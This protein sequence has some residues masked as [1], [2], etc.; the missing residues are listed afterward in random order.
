MLFRSL[1]LGSVNGAFNLDV[2][3]TA[4]ESSG[5][6]R[7]LSSPRGT[8]Q[9]NVEAEIAQGVQIPIQT[10]ANNTVTVSFKDATLSVR[11]RPHTPSATTVIMKIVLENA[12]PAF[13]RSVQ[14]IPPIN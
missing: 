12:S 4:L 1:Q 7:L 3:L 8:M 5:N 10:I 14:G 11:V 6:G 9:N 2:A 13:S